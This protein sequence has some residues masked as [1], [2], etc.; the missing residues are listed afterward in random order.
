M[1]NP[2]EDQNLSDPNY[3]INLLNLIA[4]GIE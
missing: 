1:T 3:L 4:N 2:E